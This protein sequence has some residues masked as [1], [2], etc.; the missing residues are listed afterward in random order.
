MIDLDHLR[1]EAAQYMIRHA[2]KA[3][4]DDAI[5]YIVGIAYQQGKVDGQREP[6]HSATRERGTIIQDSLRSALLGEDEPDPARDRTGA[7]QSSQAPC[8]AGSRD[9]ADGA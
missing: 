1:L 9:S 4:I 3:S 7:S 6:L 8:C 5:A 2:P